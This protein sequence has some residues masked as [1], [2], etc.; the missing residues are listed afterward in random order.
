MTGSI[1]YNGLEGPVY[2][3]FEYIYSLCNP[4]RFIRLFK[5]TKLQTEVSGIGFPFIVCKK[6]RFRANHLFTVTITK[7]TAATTYTD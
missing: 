6:S 7:L 4:I 3:F 5:K 1:V 2:L